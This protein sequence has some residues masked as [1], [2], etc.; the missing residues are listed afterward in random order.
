MNQE[1]SGPILAT[2]RPSYMKAFLRL[3]GAR[4]SR[5][6]DGRDIFSRRAASP[7]DDFDRNRL[8]DEMLEKRGGQSFNDP[9]ST[10]TNA[11]IEPDDSKHCWRWM[12]PLTKLES[13]DAVLAR[14]VSTAIF[15]GTTI[16]TDRP[17]CWM[18]FPQHGQT[19]IGRTREQWL[20][21]EMEAS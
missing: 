20:K 6:W 16:E 15:H 17:T 9:S 7:C 13:V 2:N 21:R 8:A 19:Q 10:M 18:S 4:T 5:S 14:L 3:V 11:A 12:R 1:K